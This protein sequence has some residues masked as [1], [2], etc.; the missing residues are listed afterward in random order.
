MSRRIP[1]SLRQMVAERAN[2]RC[3]YCLVPEYFL[4]SIFHIDH[5]RSVKHEG[6]TVPENLAFACPHCNQNKGSDVATFSDLEGEETT[7]IFNPR[8]DSWNEHFMS[9]KEK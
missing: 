6:L 2:F 1:P 3:E 8:K 5:I 4:A 9:A 7:R